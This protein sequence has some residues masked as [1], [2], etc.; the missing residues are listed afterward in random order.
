MQF[1]KPFPIYRRQMTF[2]VG[3]LL[4][5]G[6]L[7]EAPAQLPGFTQPFDPNTS[8][9]SMYPLQ[10]WGLFHKSETVSILT[11][12]GLSVRVFNLRG[13]T[14]YQGPPGALPSLPVDHYFVECLGDR[15]QFCVLPDDYQGASFLGVDAAN[16][17]DSAYSQRLNQIQPTWV[18]ALVD[19]QWPIVEPMPGVWNW[20]SLDRTVAANPGRKI[21]VT[22]FIRP[23]WVTNNFLPQFLTYVTAMAQRY[24][25]KIYAIQIWNEPWVET[26]TANGRAWGDIG[27]PVTGDMDIDIPVWEQTLATL[28]AT[29][30]Q[31]IRNVSSSIKVFGPDWSSLDYANLVQEV[32]GL[33]GSQTLD[34]C[35]FHSNTYSPTSDLIVGPDGTNELAT[36]ITPYVGTASWMVT[37]FHPFGASALGIPTAGAD[38]GI[39]SPG[40]SWQRGMNRLIQSVVM[41][42]A[43]GADA[44]IPHVMPMSGSN[45]GA[46]WEVY[47]WE[48]GTSANSPEGRGPH[49]KTSAYLMTGY[50]LNNATF[51]DAR[52]PGQQ[53]FLY[54]WRRPDNSSLVFAWTAEGHTASLQPSPAFTVRDIFGQTNQINAL[55]ETPVLFSSATLSPSVLMSNILM[56][57]TQNYSVPPVW[58]QPLNNQSVQVGQTLQFTVSAFDPNRAPITYSA[59]PLPS[60]ASLDPVTGVFSWTPTSAQIG[61]YD[62]TV[63]ATDDQ[64][65]SAATSTTIDVVGDLLDRLADYW[66]FDEGTG[67]TTADSSGQAHGTLANFAFTSTSGWVAGINGNALSFDGVDDWVSLDSNQISVSNNFTVTAWL[68]PRDA[69]GEGAFISVRCSYQ[70]AG[71]R[72]FIVNNNLAVQGETT[73]GWKWATFGNGSLQSGNWYHVAV[74]YDKSTIRAYINGLYQGSSYWGGDL[75]MD[76]NAHSQIGTQGSYYFNGIIDDLMIFNRTLSAQEVSRLYQLMNGSP[77][78][79]PTLAPIG[80]KKVGA[81]QILAFRISAVDIDGAALAYSATPL[82]EGATFDATNGMFMW[83]PLI[84]QVGIHN[85]TFAA[86]NSQLSDSETVTITVTKSNNVPVLKPIKPKRVRVGR[87]LSIRLS[88]KDR[89]RD[90]LIYS[91]DPLPTDATF[92]SLRRKFVWTTTN[93]PPGTY[94]LTASV[95][96]GESTNSQPVSITVY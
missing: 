89:D 36:L 81:G 57:L 79:A 14:V 45:T 66:K 17:T 80:A 27:N 61:S 85:L 67:T 12:N 62:I 1:P 86:S 16:G 83:S 26:V 55:T 31:A 33:A 54:A 60:G 88:A 40:I 92:D 72:F 59:S 19:G 29:S 3:M 84:N 5:V 50:W 18:R 7:R 47:G 25:G 6:F 10:N 32:V 56:A 42:R 90:I 95:T 44:I 46:N 93:A 82:P 63:T 77:A 70:Q 76:G 34:A 52:T 38:P 48:W 15:A 74:V 53:V 87:R 94:S 68:N 28:I 64:G 23:S 69:S 51:V 75:V 4:I 65:K 73:S 2:I 11:S 30:K 39:P 37:E 91:I 49:P 13:T 9:I 35:T 21:I 96:D 78:T 22:A 41:W 8:K 71:F 43:D 24:N 58:Q 20:E